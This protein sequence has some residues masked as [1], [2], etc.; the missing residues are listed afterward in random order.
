[1]R[2][3][4]RRRASCSPKAGPS[5]RVP[6]PGAFGMQL[7]AVLVKIGGMAYRRFM[8]IDRL[9][10]WASLYRRRRC[11]FV[12]THVFS[13]HT[14]RRVDIIR[15]QR[16]ALSGEH[17]LYPKERRSHASALLSSVCLF[18]FAHS[19]RVCVRR[20]ATFSETNSYSALYIPLSKSRS[21]Q[22]NLETHTKN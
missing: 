9:C 8:C 10:C 21:A 16:I 22:D 11:F 7:E 6:S 19:V 2:D 5:R 20:R 14:Y 12:L 13:F 17:P 15:V 3:R 1:M 4:G 18:Y